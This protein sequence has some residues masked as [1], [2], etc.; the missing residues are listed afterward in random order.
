MDFALRIAAAPVAP[1]WMRPLAGVAA[2]ALCA[3]A[4]A[5]E[6]GGNSYPIGV[7]T[8]GVGILPPEGDHWFAY[9]Q[10]YAAGHQK[11]NAGHDNV[12][13]AAF[14]LQADVVALRW[15]HVWRG[16][17]MSGASVETRVVQPFAA[18]DLSLAIARPGGVGPLDL[19]GDHAGLADTA[20]VPFILGWHGERLHQA[21]GL[22]THLPIGDYDVTRR[23]NTGRNYWQAAPFYAFTWL[24]GGGWEAS[25]KLRYA[26]N[27]PNPATHYRSGQEAT[28]EFSGGLRI[29]P[30]WAAGLNGYVYRQTSDDTVNGVPV[31]GHGNRGR[32]QALGPFL[33]ANF[34]PTV[35]LVVKLQQEWGARNRPQGTRAWLQ[36][37][38]P[39]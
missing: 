21:A 27:S 4:L 18:F 3:A 13:L 1:R 14:H 30:R 2:C 29:S 10:H 39:F 25:G 5:T 35:A 37:R 15:S 6:G 20:F 11:D 38:V 22:D 26:F 9:A 34:S 12:A 24:P 32:V 33:Q 23:V 17:R 16:L 36:L 19:G 31:N 8:Q 28:F 7:E